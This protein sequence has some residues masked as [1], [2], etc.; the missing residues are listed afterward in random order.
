MAVLRV[1]GALSLVVFGIAA[2]VYL[3]SY[4]ASRTLDLRGLTSHGSAFVPPPSVKVP[5]R[6]GWDDPAAVLVAVLAVGGA[7]ALLRLDAREEKRDGREAEGTL[8]SG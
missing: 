8:G 6:P 3:H 1:V 4:R 2:G 7:V 5:Y